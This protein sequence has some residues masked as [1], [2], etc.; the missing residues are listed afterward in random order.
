MQPHE[1]FLDS[2]VENLPDM[3]FV[4]DA[5]DLRFVRFNRAGEQ[6]LGARAQRLDDGG[7]FH[8]LVRRVRFTATAARFAARC[9]GPRPA[10][11]SR[12]SSAG[13][14]GINVNA[15]IHEF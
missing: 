9:S 8:P 13:T 12:I 5:R 15:L 7:E 4:K 14:I 10:P 6:L 11:W 1:R 3:V 2:I